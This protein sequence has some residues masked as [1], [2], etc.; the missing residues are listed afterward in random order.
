MIAFPILL[1]QQVCSCSWLTYLEAFISHHIAHYRQRLWS[2]HSKLLEVAVRLTVATAIREWPS[3]VQRSPQFQQNTETRQAQPIAT[4][5]MFHP[6]MHILLKNCNLWK[7]TVQ[8]RLH[9]LFSNMH[10]IHKHIAVDENWKLI[11]KPKQ[12]CKNRDSHV[13][14][15]IQEVKNSANTV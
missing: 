9:C 15:C 11:D 6:R 8:S 14:R 13:I 4:Y 10:K 7:G 2:W 3:F 5:E 1:N 12:G